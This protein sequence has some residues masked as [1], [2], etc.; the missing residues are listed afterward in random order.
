[1][2]RFKH[3]LD[4]RSPG[5]SAAQVVLTTRYRTYDGAD[6]VVLT[7]ALGY[8]ADPG[9][10]AVALPP[11]G[12]WRW[13][14]RPPVPRDPHHGGPALHLGVEYEGDRLPGSFWRNGIPF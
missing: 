14:V 6:P 11:V 3:A 1:M 8:R 5:A 9:V 4:T 12:V 10:L 13:W 7:Y 2:Q